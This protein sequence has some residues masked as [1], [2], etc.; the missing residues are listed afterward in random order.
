MAGRAV[1]AW[2][3][4]LLRTAGCGPIVLVAPAAHLDTARSLVEDV[5]VVAGGDTRSESVLRGLEHVRSDRVVI[6]DAVRPCASPRLVR[7]VLEA[8]GDAD[9]AASALPVEETLKRVAP[10]GRIEETVEREG[11]WR[12]Q[13]PQAFRTDALRAAYESVPTPATDEAQVLERSGRK[14]VV[15]RG[16]RT[17]VKVTF[18]EDLDLAAALLGRSRR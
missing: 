17:N 2:S 3:A 9:G 13:T 18:P 16:E 6:H 10:D 4:D 14:V 7:G 12:T 11:M 1:V 15:V 5:L 8:L